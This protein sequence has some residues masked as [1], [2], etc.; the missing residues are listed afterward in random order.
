MKL[1]RELV[2]KVLKMV[3]V[4]FYITYIVHNVFVQPRLLIME[5]VENT[6]IVFR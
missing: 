1:T 3:D 4:T 6:I 5:D 2:I